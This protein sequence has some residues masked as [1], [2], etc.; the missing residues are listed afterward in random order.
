MHRQIKAERVEF[1]PGRPHRRPGG[2]PYWKEF[3]Q[4][5][6]EGY[7]GWLRFSIRS[8]QEGHKVRTQLHALASYHGIPINVS[9]REDSSGV[10][11]LYVRRR[12]ELA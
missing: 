9:V 8:K 1:M 2:N 6:E 12:P 7:T 11:Y 4:A 3:V 10:W 5:H